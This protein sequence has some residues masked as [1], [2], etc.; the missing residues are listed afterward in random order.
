MKATFLCGRQLVDVEVPDTAEV[1]QSRFP[2]PSSKPSDIVMDA[3]HHPTGAPML[4]EALGQRRP[5]NVVV[6]VSDIT[7]PIPYARFLPALLDEIESAGVP[8]EEILILIATGMHRSSSDEERREMF[9][10]TVASNYRIEDHRASNE[11]ELVALE[12]KSWSGAQVKLNKHFM[13]AGFRFITGLVEP[14]FMAGFSGGRKA[15]CPGLAA[16]ETVQNLHGE[17]FLAD[18]RS[19]NGCLEG[20]PLHQ[21]AMSVAMLAGVDYSL[22][23]VLDSSRFVVSAY[24][25][26]LNSAHLAACRYVAECACRR[27]EKPVDVVLTSSGGY[28][29]DAT[30]YQCVKG[31]VSCLPAVKEGGTII[32]FG[33]CTEGVGSFEYSGVMQEFAGR[34]K[35]FLVRIKD[36]D[37]FIKDQWQFQM[38]C[39]ALAK[40]GE[41]NLHFVTDSLTKR[42]LKRLSVNGH[43]V[44][45]HAVGEKL[46]E[47]L[48]QAL[49]GGKTMA[50]FPEGPYCAAV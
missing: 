16:L 18:R 6:V 32:A 23:V 17:P 49:S 22:N 48:D 38:H 12:G 36:S 34:W 41:E 3:M 2:T 42:E 33:G 14:H 19:R 46:Q 40:V 24:A 31:M 29:L 5:G 39:R 44:E 7:R 15:V 35:E 47:L 4:R 25:G 30:F 11:D 1:F 50:V 9:G 13:E 27:V 45:T 10:D 20:N 43:R 28:P 21:E 37:S 26:S 8:R